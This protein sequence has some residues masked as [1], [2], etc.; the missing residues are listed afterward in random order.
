MIN[1]H[2]QIFVHSHMYI[3][4]V[5]RKEEIEGIFLLMLITSWQIYTPQYDY[6]AW[7]IWEYV[8]LYYTHTHKHRNWNV[9]MY[10][11]IH[12]LNNVLNAV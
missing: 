5:E 7:D 10:T 12:I 9:H 11:C 4:G 8:F 6:I 1:T 2:Y 3:Y